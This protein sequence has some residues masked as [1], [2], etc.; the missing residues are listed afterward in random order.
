VQSFAGGVLGRQHFTA[1]E[2]YDNAVVIDAYLAAGSLGVLG[3][4]FTVVDS[5][6]LV[7]ALHT[8]TRL[9]TTRGHRARVEVL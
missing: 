4:D 9:G 7:D 6:E 8:L 5:P 3:S 1:S 2:T